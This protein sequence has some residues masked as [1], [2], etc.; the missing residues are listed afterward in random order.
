MKLGLG[1]PWQISQ[2]VTRENKGLLLE[3]VQMLPGRRTH[4][5]IRL[6]GTSPVLAPLAWWERTAAHSPWEAVASGRGCAA[7]T[8][9]GTGK[10]GLSRSREIPSLAQPGTAGSPCGAS[11]LYH[12]S[13]QAP[14]LSTVAEERNSQAQYGH[15]FKVP[16]SR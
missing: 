6:P 3:R 4:Q 8:G 16:T 9:L 10:A 5:G 13:G 7:N 12:A 14:G 11:L 15:V 1:K 2:S